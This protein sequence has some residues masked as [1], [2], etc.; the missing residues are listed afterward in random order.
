M[1]YSRWAMPQIHEH[2]KRIMGFFCMH[3]HMQ[4][5]S[6]GKTVPVWHYM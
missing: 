3:V 1:T 5:Y 4:L 2:V 6:Y